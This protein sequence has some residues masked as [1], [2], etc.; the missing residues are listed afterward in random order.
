MRREREVDRSGTGARQER[1]RSRQ[2]RGRA[3]RS[4]AGAGQEQGGSRQEHA[5]TRHVEPGGVDLRANP[6]PKPLLVSD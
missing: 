5:E 6:L 2:E 4:E 3:G 1:D